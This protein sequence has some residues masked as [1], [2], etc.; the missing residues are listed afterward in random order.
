MN[1]VFNKAFK[2]IPSQGLIVKLIK[3]IYTTT[4]IVKPVFAEEKFIKDVFF[5]CG[6]ACDFLFFI[7]T[8]NKI[9]HWSMIPE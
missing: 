2:I 8:F 1:S 7:A 4:V 9:E 5:D 3:Y 6:A